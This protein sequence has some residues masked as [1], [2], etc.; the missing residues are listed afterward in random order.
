MFVFFTFII[1]KPYL[2]SRKRLDST[3]HRKAA[4]KPPATKV[5]TEAS[6]R[7]FFDVLADLNKLEQRHSDFA[8]EIVKD[9]Y[10]LSIALAGTII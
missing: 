1:Q 8:T 5:P 10:N 2:R 3:R 6:S 7:G 4:P 9:F